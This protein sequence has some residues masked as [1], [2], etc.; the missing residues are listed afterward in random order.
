MQERPLEALLANLTAALQLPEGSLTPDSLVEVPAPTSQLAASA[1][2]R[3]L[4]V[5]D[6]PAS[7]PVYLSASL[8]L[9]PDAA[10]ESSEGSQFSAAWMDAVLSELAGRDA[11]GAVRLMPGSSAQR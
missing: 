7:G 10:S 4:L 9:E 5:A 8:T 3:R 1:G 6:K 2:T 11:G